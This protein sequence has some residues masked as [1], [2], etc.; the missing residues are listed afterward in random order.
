VQAFERGRLAE[1]RALC[2]TILR[3]QPRHV[4]GR[5]LHATIA[6]R[7]GDLATAE[8]ELRWVLARQ[9]SAGPVHFNLARVL[10]QRGNLE[11]AVAHGHEA[12]A[13]M[14]DNPLAFGELA[15]ALEAS[16][17][18]LGRGTRRSDR[19]AEAVEAL[20]RA[21]ALAPG[22]EALVARLA[23]LQ[24]RLGDAEEATK[25]LEEGLRQRP[26]SVRLMVDL[27][28][29]RFEGGR[30]EEAETLCR[31]ILDRQPDC[32]AAY[33]ILGRMAPERIDDREIA[34]I[35]RLI[36][37]PDTSEDDRAQLLF[38]LGEVR[39]ARGD[40]AGAFD[41]FAR[42]NARRRASTRFDIAAE[43]SRFERIER[44]FSADGIGSGR[45]GSD[46][47]LP[48]FVIGMPRSGTSLIE[49]VLS[50]HSQVHGAGEVGDMPSIVD[51]IDRQ[52]E[53]GFPEAVAG[54][55]PERL[56]RYGESYARRLRLY[57]ADALRITDKSVDNFLYLGLIRMILPGA[58]IV[59]CR[60]DPAAT[61]F[62]CFRQDFAQGLPYT[63]DLGD[64]G[65]Y[66]R[67][68]RDL[69]NHWSTVLGPE[70]LHVV[71]YETFVTEPER[72]TRRLLEHCGLAW[73]G[74][75]LAFHRNPRAVRTSSAVQVRRPVHST[76]VAH[77]RNYE[78]FLGP[79]FEALGPL[80]P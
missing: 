38:I 15:M 2:Q 20:R 33:A 49:Q 32:A 72:E 11:D 54:L 34:E 10:R 68:Y 45:G 31:E 18:R 24:N 52:E 14:P 64:L 56:T 9:P 26:D 12:V 30:M 62:S 43:T 61:C 7:M 58:R 65:A 71:D 77:W 25:S 50:S 29:S 75:C 79:L 48:I 17:E 3:Q 69:M 74:A 39:D 40:Y 60:R 73:E 27:A 63:S 28:V 4:E 23:S 35:T 78:Q 22:D 47:T 1:A 80:A 53:G 59:H 57:D 19:Y 6:A 46:S 36:A 42:G 8:T 41:C 44:T 51:A 55:S 37:A 70:I 21:V 76:A 16:E 67:L 66:Y 5:H 13:L